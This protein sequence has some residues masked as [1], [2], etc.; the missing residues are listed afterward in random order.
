MHSETSQGAEKDILELTKKWNDSSLRMDITTI[1]SLYSDDCI[2]HF[3]NGQ[4]ADK[5]WVMKLLGSGNV[6]FESIRNDDVRVRTYESTVLW[7]SRTSL[8]ETYNGQRSQG[9][10]LWLR[11]WARSGS[12]WQIAAFQSTPVHAPGQ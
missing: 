12:G 1:G 5:Q 6:A 8:T 11:L 2:F 10:Y 9:Q 4:T 3:P 7:T